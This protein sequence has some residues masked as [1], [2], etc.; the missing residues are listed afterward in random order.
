MPDS[1]Y[2]QDSTRFSSFIIAML[3]V[4]SLFGRRSIAECG[5]RLVQLK[6]DPGLSLGM[7]PSMIVLVCWMPSY[8]MSG[9][10]RTFQP[11]L[12]SGTRRMDTGH[13]LRLRRLPPCVTRTLNSTAWTWGVSLTR[14]AIRRLFGMQ[15]SNMS[16]ISTTDA[17]PLGLAYSLNQPP[18]MMPLL[19]PK[20]LIRS[21]AAEDHR[22]QPTKRSTGTKVRPLST[23]GLAAFTAR[24]MSSAEAIGC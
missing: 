17:D 19:P 7:P 1:I 9:N 5:S 2:L 16:P 13:L 12:L 4:F 15:S 3:T 10:S 22:T 23:T 21:A 11:S 8:F 6:A 24:N 18:E 14:R 20:L